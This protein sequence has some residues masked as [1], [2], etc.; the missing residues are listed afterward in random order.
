MRGA[1]RGS[2][3]QADTRLA[4]ELGEGCWSLYAD[5]PTGLAPDTVRLEMMVHPGV[6][7]RPGAV[8]LWR[9]ALFS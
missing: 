2:E 7:E 9:R 6:H 4:V 5:A 1:A 8:D 3:A